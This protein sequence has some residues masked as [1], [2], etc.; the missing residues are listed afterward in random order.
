MSVLFTWDILKEFQHVLNSTHWEWLSQQNTIW[1]SVQKKGFT[2]WGLGLYRY[3]QPDGRSSIKWE[4]VQQK[5]KKKKNGYIDSVVYW[6]AV[7]ECTV[8]LQVMVCLC[9]VSR[10]NMCGGTCWSQKV[11]SLWIIMELLL[12]VFVWDGVHNMV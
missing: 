11:K 8:W 9:P 1:F 7:F 5:K 6:G 10:W 3:Q 12:F 4:D 2:I